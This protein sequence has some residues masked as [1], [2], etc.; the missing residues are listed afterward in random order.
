M[1]PGS[2]LCFWAENWVKTRPEIAPS[3]FC[4]FYRLRRSRVRVVHSFASVSDFPCHAFV[5]STHSRHS[6]RLQST[7]TRQA[8]ARV[9]ANFSI[10]RARVSHACASMLA[11]YL[12]SFLCSFHF[13]KLPLHSLSH[14]CP[15]KPET[16]NKRITT[17]NGIKEN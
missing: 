6:C 5:S 16:L 10:P 8:R 11:G 9:A 1:S 17:S 14:S 2:S 15:I 7:R 4:Y 3:V 12:L 13:C